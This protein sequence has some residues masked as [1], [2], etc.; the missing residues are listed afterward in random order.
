[1]TYAEAAEILEGSIVEYECDD[2]GYPN[3]YVLCHLT[4]EEL[5]MAVDA[6]RMRA[7]LIERMKSMIRAL[8]V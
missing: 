7:D 6:C 1:M 8:E 3:G 5:A 4:E 2:K